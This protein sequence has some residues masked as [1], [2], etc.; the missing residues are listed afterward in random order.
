M[1]GNSKEF[2]VFQC[3]KFLHKNRQTARQYAETVESH[4]HNDSIGDGNAFFFRFC[5]KEGGGFIAVQ[6][7]NQFR[8][9]FQSDKA[10]DIGRVRCGVSVH[11]AL[12]TKAAEHFTLVQRAA[13]EALRARVQLHFCQLCTFVGLYHGPERLAAAIA[14]LLICADI[15]F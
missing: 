9:L 7:Y 4:I 5:L 11:D 3:G 15:P 10:A 2:Q 8:L 14:G 1:G 12:C 6:P 13:K